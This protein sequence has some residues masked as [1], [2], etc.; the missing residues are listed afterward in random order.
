MIAVSCNNSL[1]I[2]ACLSLEST[3]PAYP[4]NVKLSVLLLKLFGFPSSRVS[5]IPSPITPRTRLS[6]Y[7]ARCSACA[8]AVRAE[9]TSLCMTVTSCFNACNRSSADMLS[10]PQYQQ[11]NVQRLTTSCD[12]TRSAAMCDDILFTRS[13]SNQRT[14]CARSVSVNPH[15]RCQAYKSTTYQVSASNTVTEATGF[16]SIPTSIHKY[17]RSVSCHTPRCSTFRTR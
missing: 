3:A 14:A 8:A 10:I 9:M 7:V 6:A 17:P 1:S 11:P 5:T 15:V 4:K 2:V 12:Q 13:L 16:S